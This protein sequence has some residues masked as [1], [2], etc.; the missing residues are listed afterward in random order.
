MHCICKNS[1]CNLL[2]CGPYHN[3]GLIWGFV[4]TADSR[5]SNLQKCSTHKLQ[6]DVNCSLCRRRIR[7]L[8][9]ISSPAG[10]NQGLVFYLLAYLHPVVFKYLPWFVCHFAF[11]PTIFKISDLST[12][13]LDTPSSLFFC[14]SLFLIVSYSF[15][16]IEPFITSV[17]V[18]VQ[19]S[20]QVLK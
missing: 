10:V 15:F 17:C 11:L 20:W 9:L 7:T 14:T 8:G 1:D 5:W 2:K 19:R 4:W 3:P 13:L 18:S 16:V 6:H 12:P